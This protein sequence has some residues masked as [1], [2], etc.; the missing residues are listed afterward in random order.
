M[1]NLL[2]RTPQQ[3]KRRELSLIVRD[4]LRNGDKRKYILQWDKGMLYGQ[5]SV[6]YLVE[7]GNGHVLSLHTM[8]SIG[9]GRGFRAVD[10]TVSKDDA[11]MEVI[12]YQIAVE[13]QKKRY[14]SQV[15]QMK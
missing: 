11:R 15:R 2:L 4:V 7:K 10:I 8:N 1:R 14:A 6:G 9:S 13:F 12:A 3:K 5:L